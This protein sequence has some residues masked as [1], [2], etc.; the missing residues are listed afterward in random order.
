[1]VGGEEGGNLIGGMDRQFRGLALSLLS[2]EKVRG[3]MSK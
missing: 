3:F 2:G 1:M